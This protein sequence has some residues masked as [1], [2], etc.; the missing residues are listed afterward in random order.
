MDRKGRSGTETRPREARG[1][2]RRDEVQA[3]LGPPKTGRGRKDHLLEPRGSTALS[4]PCFPKMREDRSV[5]FSATQLM[6]LCLNRD[7]KPTQP[8]L[9]TII[10]WSRTHRAVCHGHNLLGAEGRLGICGDWKH[11]GRAHCTLSGL[12]FC[13]R[14]GEI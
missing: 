7:R 5:V 12:P 11:A 9:G 1:R 2:E 8:I 3:H 10:N 6:K 14:E 4:P 13:Q